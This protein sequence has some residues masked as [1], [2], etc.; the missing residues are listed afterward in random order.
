MQYKKKSN[1]RLQ[2][3]LQHISIYCTFQL[4]GKYILNLQIEKK[5]YAIKK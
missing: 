5:V 4:Y 1:T 2:K 3:I